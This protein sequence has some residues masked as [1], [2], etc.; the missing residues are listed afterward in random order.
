M[1]CDWHYK[2]KQTDFPTLAAFKS[3]GFRVLGTTW[4]EKETTCNFSQYSANHG[5][6]GMIAS[7]W[8][9]LGANKLVNNWGDIEQLIHE[10][11]NAFSKDFPDAK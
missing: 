11:G 8:I 9:I 10:S 1:I 2:G 5:A 3:D 7:T 6:D 4:R